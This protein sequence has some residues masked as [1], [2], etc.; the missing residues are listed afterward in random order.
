MALYEHVFLARQDISTQQ[1]EAL[2]EQFK[3]VLEENGGKV[4]KIETWGLRTLTYRINK[5]R[6]AHYT[7]MN[8][9]APHAAVAEMER[10]MGLSEDILRFMTIRVEELDEEQSAMMQKRDRDDRR[11]G[12]RNDRG[13]RPDRGDRGDRGPRPDRR[14]EAPAA[15]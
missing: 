14:P 4:G 7:L 6:K 9:D 8:V 13:P 5:N 2:V 15:E 11:R 12:D 10:Q 3:T 1:V